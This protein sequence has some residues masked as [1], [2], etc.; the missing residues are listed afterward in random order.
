MKLR[1]VIVTLPLVNLYFHLSALMVLISY[2]LFWWWD[3]GWSRGSFFCPLCIGLAH[4]VLLNQK[5]YHGNH[6]IIKKDYFEFFH[7]NFATKKFV[8]TQDWVPML[9]IAKIVHVIWAVFEEEGIALLYQVL[10]SL[11]IRI[12]VAH[13]FQGEIRSRRNH[14]R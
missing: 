2:A 1:V 8:K 10:T 7:C 6:T 4:S 9:S 5:L 13:V 11:R 12:R 14:F 3:F